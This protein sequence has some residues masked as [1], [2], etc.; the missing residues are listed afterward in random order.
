[1]FP[2]LIRSVLH[3]LEYFLVLVLEVSKFGKFWPGKD[4]LWSAQIGSTLTRALFLFHSLF[5]A[6]M[7]ALITPCAEKT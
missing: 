2:K 6:H 1:M 3:S 4:R 5:C 7:S